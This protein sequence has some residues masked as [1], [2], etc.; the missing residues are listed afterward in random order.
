MA[1]VEMP[2]TLFTYF[3]R[4]SSCLAKVLMKSLSG[5]KFLT[6]TI[7]PEII[8]DTLP[9]ILF[10]EI[11]NISLCNIGRSAPAIEDQN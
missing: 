3:F 1:A 9:V 7:L 5:L 10:L 6:S 8:F 11:S 4:D 2:I